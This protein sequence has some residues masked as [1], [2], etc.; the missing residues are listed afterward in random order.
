[1]NENPP[2]SANPIKS[3]KRQLIAGALCMLAAVFCFGIGNVLVKIECERINVM[4]V[5]FARCL[6]ATLFMVAYFATGNRASYYQ[7]KNP[8]LQILRGFIGFISMSTLF[9]SF[10]LL[11]MMDATAI[12][13]ATPLFISLLSL[14]MLK[15]RM[16]LSQWIAIFIGFAGVI[17]IC[18]PSGNVTAMGASAA[19][20][21]AI[22]EAVVM[23]MSRQLGKYDRPL[24]SVFYHGLVIALFS[25]FFMPFVWT[26][27]TF[28]DFIFLIAT[29]AVCCAG[30]I[31]VV[32]AYNLAPASVVAP[33]LYTLI[34]W[35]ALFGYVIWGE[36]LTANLIYGM[37]VV[38]L[39]GLYVIYQE[40]RK[41][42]E[43]TEPV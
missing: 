42:K 37:P 35:G 15:E 17:V 13:F 21:S 4:Q 10:D 3:N 29:A 24:T 32:Y 40:S 33:L 7:T 30:Q 6:L 25:S 36:T 12:S 2:S 11:P 18:N 23:I 28:I 14:P 38:I 41:V 22:I 1:M 8:K 31:F 39:S 34:L 27:P 5:V 16:S 26:C 43:T 20:L 19:F 9:I